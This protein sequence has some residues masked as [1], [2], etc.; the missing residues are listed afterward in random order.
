[1]NTAESLNLVSSVF[2]DIEKS[3]TYNCLNQI[4]STN[5]NLVKNAM[6]EKKYPQLCMNL[7]EEN[8]KSLKDAGMLDDNNCFVSDLSSKTLTSLEMLLYSIVWKNGD[9]SKER[10]IINGVIAESNANLPNSGVVFYQFGKHLSNKA[11]PI[12]DQHVLR[13]FCIY[14]NREEEHIIIDTLRNMATISKSQHEQIRRYK[15]WLSSSALTSELRSRD[16]YVFHVDRVLFAL[17]KS[18]KCTND[19]ADR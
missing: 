15:N 1:M 10:H 6:R 7:G 11:E 19:E 13:A 3:T 8:I 16:K 2:R 18:I 12:I 14:E 17:G 9:L 5:V 4:I